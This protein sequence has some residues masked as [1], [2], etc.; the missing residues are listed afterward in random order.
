MPQ[1]RFNGEAFTVCGFSLEHLAS[2]AP[3]D[4]VL[5]PHGEERGKAARLEPRGRTSA[6][7]RRKS[8]RALRIQ[9]PSENQRAQGMPGARCTRSLAR[10]KKA[11]E[12][13]RHRYAET[14][15]HALRDGFTFT[16]SSP[17]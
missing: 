12:R 9:C 14:T 16:P 2:Q 11:H 10:N 7:S 13:S 4:E 1:W 6:L 8:A 15:G 3:Q 5:D 17:R